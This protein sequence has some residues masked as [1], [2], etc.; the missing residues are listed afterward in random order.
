MVE[1]SSAGILGWAAYEP[2]VGDNFGDPSHFPKTVPRNEK[3]VA[4]KFGKVDVDR[5]ADSVSVGELVSVAPG[6]GA[7]R[8]HETD[9]G[10]C[11]SKLRGEDCEAASRHGM[12]PTYSTSLPATRVI[13]THTD[14]DKWTTEEG[15]Q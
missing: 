5:P 10:H 8:E 14:L 3:K 7:N 6:S 12:E 11:E 4:R 13:E 1:H 15:Q 2:E 9:S